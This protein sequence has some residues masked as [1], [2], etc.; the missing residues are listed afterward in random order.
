MRFLSTLPV[1]LTCLAASALANPI[2]FDFA[3]EERQDPAVNASASATSSSS[4][5]ASSSGSS[6]SA[7]SNSSSASAA[8][9]TDIGYLGKTRQGAVPF[10]ANTDKLAGSRGNSPYENRFNATDANKEQFDIFKSMGNISPY[11]SSRLFP[12]TTAKK[13]LPDTCEV[14][15][16]MI[17]HRHGAR[18]PTSYSTE[19]APNFGAV[20]ANVT[21]AGNLTASGPLAF[22]K[23]WSYELGAELLVPIGSQQ[24]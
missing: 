18:Y 9:P 19:G 4:A 7:S 10:L 6:A 14:T 2:S 3:L 13:V 5:T 23:N 16:A 15:N 20:L 21:K 24:L 22:L 17:F 8:F 1:A 11:H 12:E